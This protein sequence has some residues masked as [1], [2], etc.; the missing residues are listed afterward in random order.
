MLPTAPSSIGYSISPRGN[1]D[2]ESQHEAML[3]LCGLN[4]ASALRVV[5]GTGLRSFLALQPSE[6]RD[7]PTISAVSRLYLGCISVGTT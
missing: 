4:A 3:I 1:D 7:P 6:R 5:R 2:D